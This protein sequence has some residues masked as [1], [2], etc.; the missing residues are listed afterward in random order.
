MQPMQ[1]S[2]RDTQPPPPQRFTDMAKVSGPLFSVDA[3]GSYAGSLV[4][5]KWK[6][7][8]YVRQLVTPSNPHT[9][10]Q[11]VARNHV[12]TAGSA[13]KFVNANTQVNANLTLTDELEIRAVTPAGQA[14]NGFLVNSM[15]GAGAANIDAADTL[16]TALASGEKTA[17]DTAANAL[18]APLFGV[19]QTVAGGAA[20]TPKSSGQVFFD[21][22]YGL[23]AMGIHPIPGAV[24]PVYT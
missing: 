11:E 19:I 13:Q 21:Y 3:S 15:V 14:W 2:P 18:T 23:Y 7:R 20:G 6:G 22:I 8:N 12:R 16:W 1:I 17:W 5:S 9:L 10:N 24:P 4:F